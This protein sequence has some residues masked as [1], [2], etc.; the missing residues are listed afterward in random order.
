MSALPILKSW[1]LDHHYII[2]I[3]SR[4]LSLSL[5][6]SCVPFRLHLL[7]LLALDESLSCIVPTCSGTSSPH[8]RNPLR[9]RRSSIQS[10][11]VRFH[12]SCSQS[13]R[14]SRPRQ[15]RPSLQSAQRARA[16]YRTCR[17]QLG[18]RRHSRWIGLGCRSW[19]WK[20]MSMVVYL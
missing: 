20:S 12:T 19:V 14:T 6:V 4:H 3:Y 2:L 8:R 5:E 1:H 10:S 9:F 18:S 16:G 15:R 13:V 7:I 11:T 17:S